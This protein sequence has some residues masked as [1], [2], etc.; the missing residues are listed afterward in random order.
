[1]QER[2]RQ[3]SRQILSTQEDERKRISRELHD[4]V[5]Q[6]LAGINVRLTALK[7][8]AA[9]KPQDLARNLARAQKLVEQSATVVHRFAREL[10]PTV[11]DDLGLI[12]ALRTFLSGFR[13]ETGM[14]VS[15][16]ASAAVEQ[17]NGDKRTVLFRCAQEALTN[18][19]RHAKAS[20]VDVVIQ[21][22]ERAVSL[23]ITDDGRGFPQGRSRSVH[24]GKRLGLLGMRE[25]LEMVGGSFQVTSAR[26]K[27][28]T[29]HAQIPFD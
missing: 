2:L 15:L 26:G 18:A 11:L 3:L 9:I 21:K 14:S 12:P 7:Q 10:R 29:I 17:V 22:L 8:D 24:A 19:A 6:T 16:S 27:G 4:V 25:R 20:R 1:M 5:A 23:R 28:T 13:Q